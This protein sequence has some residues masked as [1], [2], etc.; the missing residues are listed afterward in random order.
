MEKKL[1]I[2][3]DVGGT[4]TEIGVI[5]KAGQ[6]L[7]QTNISTNITQ[8]FDE[9]IALLAS[10]IDKCIDKTGNKEDFLGIGIGAPNGNYYIGTIDNAPNLLWKGILPFSEKLSQATGLKVVL[11]N[12]ANAAAIG[13][14]V[15]GGAKF[16]QH[17]A[18]I[19]LGT[20]LGSGIVCDGKVLYGHDGFAGELGHITINSRSRRLCG[21]GRHG[22]LET[23]ASATGIVVTMK[24]LLE[25]S[26]Q[27]SAIRDLKFD[28]ISSLDICMAAKKGDELA[29]K[30]FDIT[31]DVLAISLANLTAVL[32]PE[33][34]FLSGGLAKAEN[35]LFDPLLKYYNQYVL[36]LF[37]EKTQILPSKLLNKNTGLIG[38]AAL[39]LNEI[40]EGVLI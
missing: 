16:M 37:K 35:I 36:Q 12:D 21:C 29:L 23:Y 27:K 38:A 18:V 10:E 40:K 32:S 34:I 15:Y 1:V 8:N 24:S 5:N 20:G 19:T 25:K 33:A 30:A 11:T 6:I 26:N 2:G 9:Y 4:N 39:A 14:G 22:C 13:E 31:A 28:K 7:C 3:I 17:Y